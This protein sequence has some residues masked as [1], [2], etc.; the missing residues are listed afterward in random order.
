[1]P[2][3][4]FECKKCKQVFE[5]KL[6]FGERDKPITCEECGEVTERIISLP[7]PPVFCGSGWTPKH[8]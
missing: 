7:L 3:Y 6:S 2:L 4:E 5:K 8:H 1:M